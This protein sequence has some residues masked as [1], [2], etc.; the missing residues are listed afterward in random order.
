MSLAIERLNISVQTPAG[1]LTTSV[2]IPTGFVPVASI[3]PVMRRLGEQAQALET[4]RVN[5]AGERISCAKGCAACCRMLV[6]VSAPEAFALQSFVAELS[7]GSRQALL[8]KV[9]ESQLALDKAGL[10]PRLYEL[11]ESEE[12]LQDADME[13]I[14]HDYYTLRLPCPFLK[15]ETCSIYEH[16]PAA[17]RELQV[18]SPAE[19]CQDMETN[20]VRAL[21]VP[22]RVGTALSLLWRELAGGPARLIPLPIALDWAARHS[23]A[24]EQTWKGTH[25]LEK[26]LDK[27]WRFL[28]EETAAGESS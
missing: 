15:D 5:K 27:I 2:D 7:E 8:K 1:K 21:P 22:V 10:L 18:T 24:G 13:A 3:V 25:L 23:T 26:A 19:Y 6:P 11:A 16:R 20:P 14:N 17:C 9:T 28:S 4:K 12:Q